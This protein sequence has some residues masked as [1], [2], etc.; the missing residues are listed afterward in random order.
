M[1][2]IWGPWVTRVT[3]VL[4]GTRLMSGEGWQGFCLKQREEDRSWILGWTMA[5]AVG[6]PELCINRSPH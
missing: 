2:L 1:G 5:Q 6:R 4:V 3:A